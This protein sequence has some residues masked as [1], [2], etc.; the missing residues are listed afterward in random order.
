MIEEAEDYE[1]ITQEGTLVRP[2]SKIT[3]EGTVE[4]PE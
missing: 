3:Q 2:G 1:V 4:R